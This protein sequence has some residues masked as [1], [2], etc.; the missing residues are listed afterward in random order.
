MDFKISPFMRKGISD[1]F[2]NE[3]LWCPYFWLTHLI[4]QGKLVTGK[5]TSP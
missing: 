3:I 2:K 1:Y 4:S 5:T